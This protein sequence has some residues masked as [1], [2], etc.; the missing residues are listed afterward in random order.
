[1]NFLLHA[2]LLALAVEPAA[3]PFA[4]EVIDEATGRGVPLVELTTT[5]GVTYVTDSAGLV[6]F[7]EP[8]LLNQRVFFHVKSH[9]YE[10]AADGFGIRGVALAVKAG[11]SAQLKIKR[12]NIAER[13][14]RVTGEGI[15]RDSVLLDRPAPIREPLLNAQVAGCDSVQ[16]AIY[17]GKLY[18]FWGDT[19]RPAYPLGNF[20]TTGATSRLPGD[21]GL[22]PAL[23]VDL[24]YF[25][26]DDGFA[27]P[28][29]KIPGEGPTW[30]S[31]VAVLPNRDGHQRLLCGYSKIKPPLT[32]Y[33]RGVA[34]WDGSAD[35][36]SRFM[37]VSDVSRDIP[38][39]PEGNPLL[40]QEG[41]TKYIYF[42]TP[43]PLVR[44]KATAESY[45]DPKMY[46]AYTCLKPGSTLEKPEIDRDEAC[47]VRYGWKRDTPLVGPQQQATLVRSGKLKADEAL[48]QLRDVA[49]GQEVLAH[50]GSVNW[51]E[52]RKRFVM[53]AVQIYGSSFLGEVWY[54]E[55]PTPLGPW[56]SAVKIASHDKYSFYN[57][58]QHPYFDQQGGRIIYFEGTYSHTFSGNEHATPRYDYNQVMY[59][60]D[61]ADER[62]TMAQ[63]A[64]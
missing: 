16:N 34:E 28:M 47:R 21:G 60:L 51:N 10:F 33:R 4:I 3:A 59:R 39:F 18:W 13:L 57:P 52:Y 32:V 38:L 29:A 44:T 36:P 62:L 53:I 8:G 14:Y 24:D 42:A 49:T 11:G 22:D 7:S 58:K 56:K 45:C 64:P 27:R 19:N 40:Y 35:G 9:G 41:E 37:H 61:L 6:A 46:E 5:S 17:H 1:M 55:A 26:G 20:H 50:A 15:Y 30:I 63:A 2:A 54:A 12:L 48:I 23:G 25:A 43:Y 31:G